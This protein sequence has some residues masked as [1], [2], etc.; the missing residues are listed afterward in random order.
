MCL[1][2]EESG[3]WEDV[4]AAVR[5][6]RLSTF[7]PFPQPGQPRHA[8][9][10]ACPDILVRSD[11]EALSFAR[12]ARGPSGEVMTDI[13]IY[14]GVYTFKLVVSMATLQ[15]R[16]KENASNINRHRRCHERNLRLQQRNCVPIRQRPVT[17]TQAYESGAVVT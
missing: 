17:S 8:P 10:K 13:S 6:F 16:G 14:T 4:S 9:L 3:S 2:P 5:S 7:E 12:D 15:N 11:D 1:Y